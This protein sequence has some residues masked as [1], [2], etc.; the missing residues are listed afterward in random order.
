MSEEQPGVARLRPTLL[1]A[2]VTTMVLVAAAL[3]AINAV[4]QRFSLLWCWLPGVFA[5]GVSAVASYRAARTSG[6][7]PAAARLWRSFVLICVLVGLATLGDAR[8]SVVDPARAALQQHDLP[9]SICLG[10]ALCALIVAL[11]RMPTDRRGR[12]ERTIRYLLDSL[13][14]GATLAVF[15]WYFATSAGSPSARWAVTPA[16]GVTAIAMLVAVALIK[17]ALT[18]LGGLDRGTVRWFAAAALIGAV[19]GRLFPLLVD[20]RPGLSGAQIL[21]PVTMTCVAFAADRQ[22]R[23]GAG[24]GHAA[25]RRKPFSVVPYAAVAATDGLLLWVGGQ[26]GPRV[27]VVAATAAFLTALVAA[28]QIMALRDNACLLGRVDENLRQLH[29]YQQE[30]THQATHDVLT[31]LANRALF[32]K[33]AQDAFAG[34]ADGD[35]L[36]LALVDLDDFKVV[37]DR[38]G[39]AVGDA[40]LVAVA[41]RLRGSI[42]AGDLVARLG[43]DEFGLVL[44]GLNGRQAASVLQRIREALDQPVHADGHELLVRASIGLAEMSPGLTPQ[45]LMLRADAAMYA[46]K[47]SGKGRHAVYDAELDQRQTNGAQIGAD[48]RHA[49]ESGQLSLAY[50]PVVRLPDGAWVGLEALVRW[51][52]PDR[53]LLLPDVFIPIAE[54]SGLIVPLGRWIL[55]TALDQYSAWTT[56]HGPAAPAEISVNV[57]TRQLREPG[58]VADIR[59]ALAA[60]GVRPECLSI[61]VT[62]TA[63][64]DNAMIQN[65]LREI[66]GIGVRVTID[67]FGTGHSSLGLLRTVPTHTLKVDSAELI[68]STALAQVADVLGLRAVAESVETAHQADALHQLGYRYAQGYYFARPLPPGEVSRILAGGL[69][70]APC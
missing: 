43:G 6:L 10:I 28:R 23:A 35:T 63:V 29:D 16:L 14:V 41:G 34:R 19:G 36:C 37:N 25:Q 8:Q 17:V 68:I 22:V 21:A 70:P 57:S 50:Q 66:A 58:F 11:L 47:G 59:E 48:L 2:A 45:E 56:E 40:L 31:G 65:V 5:A 39:H 60:T 18:G 55:R 12:R 33:A 9:T 69:V 62:E 44:P 32:E 53:G 42:R 13:T 1:L 20:V 3:Y 15:T 67:D 7:N 49:M 52:H 46:A 24:A 51:Q 4:E 27:F 54:R 64:F 61:E 26:I 30:L 38:L